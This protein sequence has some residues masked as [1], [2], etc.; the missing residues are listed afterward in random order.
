MTI[1]LI[2]ILI[3]Y[4]LIACFG[5][6]LYRF[7]V[8]AKITRKMVHMGGG[9]ISAFLPFWINWP[10]A[11]VI[12]FILFFLVLITKKIKLFN[13][14]HKDYKWALGAPLFPI[15]LLISALIYWPINP[16]IFQGSAL[17]LGFSDGLAGLVGQLYGVKKYRLIGGEKSYLG[18]LACGLTSLTIFLTFALLSGFVLN[19]LII[20]LLG[21]ITIALME[22]IVGK[23]KD[24]LILPL[25][26]GLFLYFLI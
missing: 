19:D 14:I 21:A 5:E 3:L 23:G 7:G 9:M 25:A 22:G 2:F 6:V 26:G 1:L 16:L 24:N 18:S 20:S 17:I 15:G 4:G 12:F 8:P 13:G 11:I 10:E